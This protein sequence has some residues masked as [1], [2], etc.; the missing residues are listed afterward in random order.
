MFSLQTVLDLGKDRD[1]FHNPMI[2][3]LAICAG[4]GFIAWVIW[5]LTEAQPVVDLSLFKRRNFAF[6]VIALCLGY[7]LFFANNLLLPLWLQEQMGYTATWAGFVAAPSGIVAVIATPFIGRLKIDARWLATAAFLCFAGSYFMR[8]HY[9]PD[10]SFCVLT[11]PLL[12]Q[13]LAMSMFFVPLLTILLDGI[14]PEKVPSASGI[15][16]FARITAGSFAASLITTFWDRREALHQTRL[17]EG[18]TDYSPIYRQATDQMQAYG[19]SPLQAAGSVMRTAINQAYLLS[20][21]ELFW[22]CG[23]MAVFAIGAIW[24]TRKPAPSAHVVAAD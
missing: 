9:T 23:W 3:G 19:M 1:W 10:A 12:L 17:V 15:S 11:A 24:I 18:A 20:T 21:L 14:P 6:G 4:V 2:A 5:E 22:I 8:S 7:A 13:G 16:N